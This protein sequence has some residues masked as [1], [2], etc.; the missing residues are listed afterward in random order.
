MNTI[1]VSVR[2]NAPNWE[3][4]AEYKG[5][6]I[7]TASTWSGLHDLMHR[8]LADKGAGERGETY[9]LQIAFED[10]ELENL[11]QDFHKARYAARRAN[12]EMEKA[13]RAA[14]RTFTHISSTRDAGAILGYSHQY[15]AKLAPG[16]R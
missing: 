10:P 2:R 16:V 8:V 14:A 7:L 11:V 9:R 3:A 12:E 13:L 4:E 1:N 5:S 6:M 15:I